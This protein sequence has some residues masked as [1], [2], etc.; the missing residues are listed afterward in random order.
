MSIH[1]TAVIGD[2][3]TLA[4]NVTIGPFCVLD[5]EISIDAGTVLVASVHILGKVTI[6]EN[7]RIHSHAV[8]GDYPQDTSF[9]PKIGSKVII[10]NSNSIREAVTIHRGAKDNGVTT[11]GNHS[12]LMANSHIG[13]DSSVGDHTIIANNV[14]LGGHVSVGQHVFLGGGAGL[15]QF[16]KVGDYAMSKGNSSISQDLPPYC[17]CAESNTLKGLNVVGLKR[18]GFSMEE[19]KEIKTLYSLL[20]RSQKNLSEALAEADQTEWSEKAQLLLN[21]VKSPSRKHVMS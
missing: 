21:A 16:V 12:M 19:R 2:S 14:M 5:G 10:G 8:I 3:V 9:T 11:I 15:H 4:E 6:G 1:P 17:I 18:N 13:H 7:N 20:F